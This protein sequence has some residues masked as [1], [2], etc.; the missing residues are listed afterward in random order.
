MD[1]LASGGK[2]EMLKGSGPEIGVD[3]VARLLVQMGH[4][5]G[6]LSRVRY[7]SR[8]EDKMDVVRQQDERLLPNDATFLVSHIVDL[9]EDHPAHFTHYFRTTVQHVPQNLEDER[10]Q[11]LLLLLCR[12]DWNESLNVRIANMEFC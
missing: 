8:K 2:N 10:K 9:V 7:G 5:F 1:A 12:F 3:H 4:P 11:L 6:E